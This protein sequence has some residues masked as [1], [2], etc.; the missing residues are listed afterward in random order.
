MITEDGRRL[1]YGAYWAG[2]NPGAKH[3]LTRIANENNE[4]IA[5]INYGTQ[6]LPQGCPN[7]CQGCDAGAGGTPNCTS[8]APYIDSVTLANGTA[9]DFRYV[10]MSG[11]NGTE[12]VLDHVSKGSTVL[13]QYSYSRV[14][15]LSAIAYEP[16]TS[17]VVDTYS[18]D[19]GF[20][21]E[22]PRGKLGYSF[23]NQGRVVESAGTLQDVTVDWATRAFTNNLAR[24][25]YGETMSASTTYSVGNAYG[26]MEPRLSSSTETVNGAAATTQYLWHGTPTTPG[27]EAGTIDPAGHYSTSTFSQHTSFPYLLEKTSSDRGSPD[28][29]TGLEHEDYTYTYGPAQ[30]PIQRVDEVRKDTIIPGLPLGTKAVHK[31]IYWDGTNKLKE[32]QRTGYTV[33]N[34][35]TEHPTYSTFYYYNDA[36]P[37]W[38]SP[39]SSGLLDSGDTYLEVHGPCAPDSD[40]CAAS[41][42][43]VTAYHYWAPGAA[44]PKRGELHKVIRYPEGCG[45]RTLV[46]PYVGYDDYGNVTEETDPNGV[47]TTYTWDGPAHRMLTRS[48]GG[49]TTTYGYDNGELARIQHP[50][51]N[52]EVFCHR[53][54]GDCT[55]EW[56]AKVQWKAKAASS[57]GDGWSEKV[58]Y[59]YWPDGSLNAEEYIDCGTT[60]CG[61]GA[62]GTIRKI[63]R[64]ASDSHGNQIREGQGGTKNPQAPFFTQRSPIEVVRA[65][66]HADNLS[67]LGQPFVND[68]L[69]PPPDCTSGTDSR[70]TA[71]RYDMAE[72]L[73]SVSEYASSSAS[74]RTCF[75]RDAHGNVKRVAQGCAGS[76]CGTYELPTDSTC[77][78]AAMDYQYDDFGNLV[79]AT[80][81]DTGTT[82]R[83]YITYEYDAM[84]NMVKKVTEEMRA[85]SA[86]QTYTYDQM[87][88]LKATQPSDLSVSLATYDYDIATSG[89]CSSFTAGDAITNTA[90]RL[91]RMTDSFGKTWYSYDA[92]GRVIRELRLRSPTDSRPP[93]L[94]LARTVRF[95]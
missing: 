65:Y 79:K 78:A 14:G 68:G 40:H 27:A 76:S 67:G 34:G 64:F 85:T 13:V 93:D 11:P 17:N 41:E 72:R 42:H 28:G 80:L 54:N 61:T 57:N 71:L 6:N 44:V 43:P 90:G 89:E 46:T 1:E 86:Y 59:Y 56:N 55:G 81:P 23:D 73:E 62:A 7:C 3:F 30:A 77:A 24:G 74:S 47:T 4:T 91:R 88:R 52:Y 87:G 53:P 45:Y 25:P 36:K 84:G 33:V 38:F 75:W 63:K 19:G 26:T 95:G 82:Q 31:S 37:G 29:G 35:T 39:C 20:A 16:A 5:T 94:P 15:E 18:Y 66:D 69:T 48:I 9:L 70:C 51:G 92:E 32:S 60:S 10:L 8:G 50:K 21:F 22:T 83:G 58:K 49:H 2:L 12:C